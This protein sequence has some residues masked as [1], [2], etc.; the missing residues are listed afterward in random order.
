MKLTYIR[1][2]MTIIE[3]QGL[4]LIT[5]P[6]FRMLGLHQAPKSYTFERM[7]RPDL[8]FISHTHPYGIKRK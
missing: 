3:T 1:W 2:S 7:P 5:D 8:V 6:V 4:T